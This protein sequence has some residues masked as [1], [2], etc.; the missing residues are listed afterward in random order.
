MGHAEQGDWERCTRKQSGFMLLSV[1]QWVALTDKWDPREVY[2]RIF[3]NATGKHSKIA[4]P[5]LQQWTQQT[6][7][8]ETV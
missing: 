5:E 3:L 4:A 2:H 1:P 7:L 8:S 6:F